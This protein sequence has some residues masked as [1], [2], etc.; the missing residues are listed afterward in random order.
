VWH[1]LRLRAAVAIASL[2][3]AVTA[4]A[5]DERSLALA[6]GPGREL[7]QATCSMCHSVDYILINAPFQDRTGWEKTVTKM[8]KVFGAPLTPEDNAAIVAY[9]AQHYGPA[10]DE[11]TKP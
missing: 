7:T 8:V 4:A 9:L 5:A 2:A 10:G 3:A 1:D 11:P 6:D